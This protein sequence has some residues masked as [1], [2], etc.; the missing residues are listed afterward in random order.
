MIV[1]NLLTLCGDITKYVHLC[2]SVTD[3]FSSAGFSL[4]HLTIYKLVFSVLLTKEDNREDTQFKAM[5]CSFF[6]PSKYR[7]SVRN[8]AQCR[9]RPRFRLSRIF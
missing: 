3:I 7:F 9:I 1:S 2:P 6:G 5:F 8:A 4:L